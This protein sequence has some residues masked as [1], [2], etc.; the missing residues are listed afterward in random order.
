MLSH[1][2]FKDGEIIFDKPLWLTEKDFFGQ[3]LLQVHYLKNYIL[4]VG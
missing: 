3:D 4:N 1:I 2:D